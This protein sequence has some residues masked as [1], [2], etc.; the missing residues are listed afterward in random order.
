MPPP[1]PLSRLRT[2]LDAAIVGQHDAKL[3]LE[4]ALLAEQHALLIG[5]SGCGKS[6]LAEAAL[7]AS[8]AT[9]ARI[10]FHRDTRAAELLGE[11]ALV[12]TPHGPGE[13]LA[14]RALPGALARAEL[15]L[16]DDLE[17]AP[18][19][20]LAPLL[21][22]LGEREAPSGALP[23][24]SAIATQLPR[25]QARHADA[26]EPAQ[27]DRFA[28]QVRLRG[29]AL[30]AD[31]TLAGVLLSRASDASPR[32]EVAPA[33]LPAASL[34][35]AARG[36]ALPAPLL[37][38][39]LALWRRIAQ[40]AQAAGAA[41]AS[42]RVVS[43]PGLAVLR[44]H[45]ALHGRSEAARADLRAARFMLAAR[46]PE[47]LLSAAEQLIERA[48]AGALAPPSS[49]PRAGRALSGDA[50]ARSASPRREAPAAERS[51]RLSPIAPLRHRPEPADVSR[52]VRAL[53]GQ[54][55]RAKAERAPDP[56]GSPRKRAPLRSL[57]DAADADTVELALYARAS[58][59]GGPAL[60]RRER[61]SR[62]GALVLL[63]D[64]S[65]SM[66]GARTRLAADVVAGLVRAAAKRRMRVA[67]VEF[68]H[69][70]EPFLVDGALFHRRYRALL[71][72]ARLA[73]A[74][75][76]TSY[77][78]PLRVALEGL[79]ALRQRGGH[80]ALLTDG[81]PVV[82]DA[83]AARERALARELGARIH[84][85]FLGNEETPPLL[86][87]L[88]E[89]TGGLC[90][91]VARDRGRSALVPVRGPYP[92]APLRALR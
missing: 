2:A 88:A 23:L 21:R 43:A 67:Y 3:A 63:R 33:A 70:A 60:L 65:A 78:A 85:V 25:N 19:E 45:A 61:R 73:R 74:E 28:V 18:G 77:E 47:A 16:L 54:L 82:G 13:R 1:A 68:H 24:R 14:L 76:R 22:M 91:R 75:G 55:D 26:L 17:R 34:A 31:A 27:L 48:A 84:T 81:V 83:R 32:A 71:E 66:E 15:W 72:R 86:V 38:E 41:S 10:A 46:V 52:L 80:I 57:A 20:A 64:I 7:A 53:R 30:Q 40:L 92:V 12:R 11:V 39:W 35:L 6:A 62:G 58:W 37:A 4:L 49:T 5:P 42:D 29:L 56:G 9:V 51:A 69:D 8:G 89:E 90:F 87:E 36:V 50:G 59:P 44:A 79:R